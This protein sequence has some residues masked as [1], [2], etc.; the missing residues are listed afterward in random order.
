MPEISG[1]TLIKFQLHRQPFLPPESSEQLF[2]NTSLDMLFNG[3]INQLQTQNN[4]QVI[5]GEYG[6]GKTSFCKKLL[7]SYS[8]GLAITLHAA[9][10]KHRSH[11]V[12][13]SLAGEDH[14]SASSDLQDLATKAANRLFKLLRSELQP[15]LVID[16]AHSLPAKTLETLLK[17]INAVTK[18]GEGRV[19]VLL[20][21]ERS[22]DNTLEKIDP[23]V[24]NKE[25]VHSTLLRPF[26]RQD[27]ENYIEFRLRAA[28]F[29]GELPFSKQQTELIQ[30]KCGGL[31]YKIDRLS[32][33]AL[34]G[35]LTER[36]SNLST[37]NA[38]V[39]FAV[40][41]LI[42]APLAYWLL[43]VSVSTATTNDIIPDSTTQGT[44]QP[45]DVPI[46]K[47][48]NNKKSTDDAA[49]IQKPGAT[50]PVDI[51]ETNTSAAADIGDTAS[52]SGEP[53][54]F[55]SE[56]TAG[57]SNAVGD[58]PIM[59]KESNKLPR[60]ERWLMQQPESQYVVQ[61]I[62][63]WNQQNLLDFSN[64]LSISDSVV[65]IER[66]RN[67]QSWYVLLYGPFPTYEEALSAVSRL[68]AE[69]Q[70]NNPWIRQIASLKSNS[71]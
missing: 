19:K 28:G 15:V 69:I 66:P 10:R 70:N 46:V 32:C 8:E 31:P 64:K 63:A 38:L 52:P 71:Q 25:E 17:F 9:T 47:Q 54:I 53:D 16:D 50:G 23:S 2:S 49:P 30:N 14:S 67:N 56:T 35:K 26:T 13:A 33:D 45:Q 29:N 36:S 11:Q 58:T 48:N 68:P 59:D 51:G 55:S 42:T 44:E 60:S 62:G 1:S 18:Q 39:I 61:L 3:V 57:V 24:L 22:I 65:M 7:F 21:G 40:L 41:A 34:E 12:F 37:R 4:I 43:N 20:I 6:A 5:K 27:V